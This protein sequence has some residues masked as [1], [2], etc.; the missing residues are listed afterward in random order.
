MHLKIFIYDTNIA[1]ELTRTPNA[2]PMIDTLQRTYFI[3]SSTE[4]CI[5]TTSHDLACVCG[6]GFV[7]VPLQAPASRCP[8]RATE[9]WNHQRRGFV[10][11]EAVVK[12]KILLCSD[13]LERRGMVDAGTSDR[14]L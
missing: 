13:S 3:H 11:T 1:F 14:G 6:L 5:R 12:L 2:P 7:A 8:T 4:Y 10:Q 9:L